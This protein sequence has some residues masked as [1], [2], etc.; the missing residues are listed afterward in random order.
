MKQLMMHQGTIEIMY[1][2]SAAYAGL[3]QQS[4]HSTDAALGT[5]AQLA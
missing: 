4:A 2:A 1:L 3:W 5:N